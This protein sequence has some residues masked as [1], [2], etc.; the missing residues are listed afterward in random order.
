MQE[1]QLLKF[2][3]FNYTGA[4]SVNKN[5]R[6][7]VESLQYASSLLENS[8]NML[9]IYPQGKIYSLYE[10][11][12][13]FEQGI[14]RVLQGKEDKI[15]LVFSANLIDYFA[16]SKP[17]LTMYLDTY[18]GGFSKTAIE[19]SYNDFYKNCVAA[20]KKQISP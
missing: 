17:S 16:H 10:N 2:R 9:L 20:Q 14:E 7:M 5:S 19:N 18:A 13:R 1:D 11:D 8:R 12:F 4:F 3:F 6:E 15:Q